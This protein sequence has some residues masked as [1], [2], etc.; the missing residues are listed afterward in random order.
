MPNMEISEKPNNSAK[1]ERFN[2]DIIKKIPPGQIPVY[3]FF[4]FCLTIFKSTLLSEINLINGI[5]LLAV[6]CVFGIVVVFSVKY[7]YINRK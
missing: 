3:L 6:I 4:I 7:Y 5:L 1:K 2:W